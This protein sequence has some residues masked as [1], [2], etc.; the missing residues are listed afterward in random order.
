MAV[1]LAAVAVMTRRVGMPMMCRMMKR[2]M[3]D[4]E[5]SPEMRAMMEKCGC[6]PAQGPEDGPWVEEPG[7]A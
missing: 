1:V 5:M 4:H 2:F 7:D 6:A 3:S